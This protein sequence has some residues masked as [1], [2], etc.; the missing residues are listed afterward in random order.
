MLKNPEVR[1]SPLQPDFYRIPEGPEQS[2]T[3]FVPDGLKKSVIQQN[4]FASNNSSLIVVQYSVIT[5][6]QRH[7]VA[8]ARRISLKAES[9]GGFFPLTGPR[10][11][12]HVPR[13]ASAAMSEPAVYYGGRVEQTSG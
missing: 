1:A 9:K 12:R 8:R 7:I 2:K 10:P 5:F 6:G 13:L 11:G 4:T 3:N